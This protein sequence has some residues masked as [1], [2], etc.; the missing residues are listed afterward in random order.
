MAVLPIIPPR[1][2]GVPGIDSPAPRAWYPAPAAAWR[3]GAILQLVTTG[4][5]VTPTPASTLATTAGPSLGGLG[6]FSITSSSFSVTAGNLTVAGASASSA[7]AATY[8]CIV[9]YTASGLESLPS[10][11]F[12]CSC[13]AGVVP[14]ITVASAGAPGSA[15][16]WAL[17]AGLFSGSECLQQATTT[18][19]ALGS[20]FTMPWTL[21]NSQG[22]N[23]G[24]SNMNSGIVGLAMHDVAATYGPAFGTTNAGGGIGG[25][26]T[27]GAIGN[28]L[29]TWANPPPLGPPDPQQALVLSVANQVPV[30]ISLKQAYYNVLIGSSVGITL[31][32]TS[33][34]FYADTGATACGTISDK[35]W[36]SP[37]DVGGV[38]DQYGRIL[39]TFTAADCL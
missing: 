16:D 18:T 14:K 28:E 20:S 24:A 11:E 2:V 25:S 17:F 33:G 27:G 37:A 29:G 4:T 21:T 10:A 9:A 13:P 3:E 34:Y 5:I 38:G 7:P 12:A 15:T 23:N 36:G 1:I 35:V 22:V 32:S 31:D 19:T 26:F 8:Y 6:P 39:M 30:E